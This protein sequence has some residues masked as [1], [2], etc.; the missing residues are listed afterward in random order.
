MEQEIPEREEWIGDNF[1]APGAYA[2]FKDMLDREGL[3]DRWHAF[4]N[5]TTEAVFDDWCR[6]HGIEVLSDE[7]SGTFVRLK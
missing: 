3:L 2:R 6:A 4:E 1:R 7:E 5:E